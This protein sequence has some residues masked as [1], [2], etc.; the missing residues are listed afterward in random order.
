METLIIRQIVS[1]LQNFLQND[2]SN[3]F[4]YERHLLIDKAPYLDA[5]I[6]DR[7]DL[8]KI[9]FGTEAPNR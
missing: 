5:F 2:T 9:K 4:N 1:D 7:P 6:D 8:S 3:P